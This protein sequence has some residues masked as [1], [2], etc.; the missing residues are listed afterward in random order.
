MELRY[1]ISCIRDA[2]P[3][4]VLTDEQFFM[5]HYSDNVNYE[6][7]NIKINPPKNLQSLFKNFNELS[8]EENS[9]DDFSINCFSIMTLILFIKPNLIQ[10]NISQSY[11]LI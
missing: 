11:I 8:S 9:E 3:F 5:Y 7:S 10:I 6:T 1:C 4:S 2:M